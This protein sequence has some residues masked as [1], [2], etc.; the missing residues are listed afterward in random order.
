M[1]K[2]YTKFL[3][4]LLSRVPIEISKIGS[5]DNFILNVLRFCQEACIF[6]DYFLKF[7]HQAYMV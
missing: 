2:M 1:T 5:F 3:Y 6:T 4:K 7:C